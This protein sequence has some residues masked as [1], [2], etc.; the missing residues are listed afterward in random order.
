[1][2]FE[3]DGVNLNYQLEGPEGAPFLTFSHSLAA[4]LT[5]WDPQADALKG[6]YRILRYD[7][8]GHGGSSAPAAPYDFGQLVGDAVALLDHL[9]IERTHFVGLSMGGMTALGL[10]LDH[11]PRLASIT[12]ANAVASMPREAA[13]MWDE[14]IE[15]ART[16]G[17][18]ALVE[19]TMERW[20][21]DERRAEGGPALEAVRAM[22]ANTKAEGYAGCVGAI[23]GLNYGPRLGEITLPA[24]FIAGEQDQATP[25]DVMRQMHGAVPGSSF[26]SLDPAAHI[27]NLAQPERFTAALKDFLSSTAKA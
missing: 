18:A 6:A 22:I 12:V 26:I 3:A 5:M 11:A 25:G 27:S 23:K 13:P 2:K 10:A 4:D 20:F 16:K 17:M 14:R 15:G 8:R 9:G 7:T 21:T 1:M 24:L 19:G